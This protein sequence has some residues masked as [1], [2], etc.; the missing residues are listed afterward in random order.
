MRGEHDFYAL[1]GPEM[2]RFLLPTFGFEEDGQTA[3][4]RM[5]NLRVPDAALQFVLGSFTEAQFQNLL[6]QFFAFIAS[7]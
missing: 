7:A 6:D 4:Y 2:K 5:E 1:A 3:S